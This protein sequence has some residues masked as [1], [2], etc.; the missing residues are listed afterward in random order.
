MN[1]IWHFHLLDSNSN[2]FNDCKYSLCLISNKIF[3]FILI[4][5]ACIFFP[6]GQCVCLKKWDVPSISTIVDVASAIK[7]FL[8]YTILQID[9]QGHMQN[10]ISTYGWVQKLMS[11]KYHNKIVRLY[12][13]SILHPI[14]VLWI[15]QLEVIKHNP[16]CL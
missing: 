15:G 10:H 6:S 12:C 14:V 5:L 4:L 1:N 9:H 3:E 7:H 11:W 13:A 16:H 8:D 2:Q